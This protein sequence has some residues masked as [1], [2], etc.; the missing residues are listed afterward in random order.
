MAFQQEKLGCLICSQPITDVIITDPE[1]GVTTAWFEFLC[2]LLGLHSA[3]RQSSLF[4]TV[5]SSDLC[6]NCRG[7]VS[8]G[9]KIRQQIQALQTKLEVLR[10]SLKN[11]ILLTYRKEDEVRGG[12]VEPA[13]PKKLFAQCEY[14]LFFNVY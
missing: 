4:G 9:L 7:I 3:F 14:A 12:I 5:E 8:E 10:D 6:S 2:E 1:N 13:K 11:Q